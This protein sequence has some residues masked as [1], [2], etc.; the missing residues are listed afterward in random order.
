LAKLSTHVLD[1]MSGRPASGVRVRLFERRDGQLRLVK[2]TV[3]NTDG[4]TDEPLLSGD[5][6]D[7]GRYRIVFDM[8]S[9]FQSL[10][11]VLADPPFLEDVALEFGI[12]DSEGSYHVPLVC[13]P[14]S[15]STYR[16]S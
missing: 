7:T 2:E 5:T 14:W 16:G 13:T 11:V 1:T 8:A 3:T 6:I 10:G 12:A 4:R 9:Y 15:Y